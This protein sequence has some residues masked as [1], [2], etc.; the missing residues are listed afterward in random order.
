[1]QEGVIAVFIPIFAILAAFAVAIVAMVLK[2]RAKDRQHRERMFLAEKGLEI[3]PEL[4][5]TQEEKKPSDFRAVRALL[6]ILGAITFFVGI[7]V[8][9]SLTTRNGFYEGVYGMIPLFIGLGFLAAERM[10]VKYVVKA[11]G[12]NN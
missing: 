5:G 6:M 9:V 3:P 8:M 2:S 7:G 11:N 4:Y 1:M 10:I 12:D